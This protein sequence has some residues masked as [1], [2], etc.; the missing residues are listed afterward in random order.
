MIRNDWEAKEKRPKHE[1]GA[2]G[3]IL[4]VYISQYGE[5]GNQTRH[6]EQDIRGFALIGP[7]KLHPTGYSK[8]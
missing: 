4:E 2:Q 6:G 5:G 8:C 1:K 7:T 3:Y